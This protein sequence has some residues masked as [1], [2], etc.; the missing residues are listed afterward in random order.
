MATVTA[1]IQ[2]PNT[3]GDRQQLRPQ[4]R[5]LLIVATHLA[6]AI[7]LLDL[8]FPLGVAAGVPYVA[9]VLLALRATPRVRSLVAVAVSLLTI[10]GF[11]I[12]FPTGSAFWLGLEN[13]IIALFA[14]WVSFFLGNIA[15]RRLEQLRERDA[16]ISAVFAAA[17]DSIITLDEAGVIVSCN[18]ATSRMFGIREED[19]IGRNLGLL[20]SPCVEDA[21]FRKIARV[22]SWM[23]Y[24]EQELVAVRFDGSTFPVEFSFS[25]VALGTKRLHAGI[26]RDVTSRRNTQERLLQAERLAAI[27]QALTGLAHE[28]RNALQRSQACIELLMGQVTE[29]GG[30]DLIRDI[31]EAQDE[32]H[33]LYEEV[34]EYAAPLRIEA[35]PCNLSDIAAEAWQLLAHD[36]AKRDV[37]FTFEGDAPH[38]LA[39]VDP[40]A[41][42]QLFRN[43]LENSLGVCQD[44]VQICIRVDVTRR[45]KLPFLQVSV[46]DNGPGI[47]AGDASQVFDPFYTTKTRGT[48]LGLAICRRIVEAH[49]GEISVANPGEPGAEFVFLLPEFGDGKSN[50]NRDCRRRAEATPVLS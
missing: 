50:A 18:P 26:M 13:R 5:P 19:L 42:R 27:G 35:A 49:G 20:L 39:L 1:A 37:A 17:N 9:V 16:Q 30:Q 43:L 44:P 10:A 38:G 47:C 28:S 32:L 3:A 29:P 22:E 36:W 31:Q 6:V 14:I 33:Y 12:P 25:E 4:V 7:F 48:G 23:H 8:V 40:F 11:F 2:P 41:A 34:R 21:D 45:G 46:R 15:L 24:N